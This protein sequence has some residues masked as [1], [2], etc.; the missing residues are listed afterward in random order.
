MPT[1]IIKVRPQELQRLLAR[2]HPYLRHKAWD[3]RIAAGQAYVAPHA[4]MQSSH[5]H[6]LADTACDDGFALNNARIARAMHVR[7]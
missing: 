5:P 4:L 3:T 2:I 7:S 1:Q 6:V